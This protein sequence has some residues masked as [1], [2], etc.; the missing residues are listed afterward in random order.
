MAAQDVAAAV[1]LRLPLRL[2]RKSEKLAEDAGVSLHSLILIA[3]AERM[4]RL[5]DKRAARKM[6]YSG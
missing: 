4:R 1:S 2:R 3:L 5:K 6:R